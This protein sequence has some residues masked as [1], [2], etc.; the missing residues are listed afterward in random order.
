LGDTWSAEP[1]CGSLPGAD[2]TCEGPGAGG[3]GGL[4]GAGGA[5]G[6]T[7]YPPLGVEDCEWF[8]SHAR[9]GFAE[10]YHACVAGVTETPCTEDYDNA[11]DEC[12]VSVTE[13]VC[14]SAD[15]TTNCASIECSELEADECVNVLKIYPPD[16]Q[17]EIV[18]C[19][20]QTSPGDEAG[21][22]DA[23]LLCE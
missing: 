6:A 7:G 12:L 14:E 22:R 4:G 9:R 21:C 11:V 8:V 10:A 13:R 2:L 3:A 1:D 18:E 16:E 5:A 15:A 19:F 23:F 17:T 20:E